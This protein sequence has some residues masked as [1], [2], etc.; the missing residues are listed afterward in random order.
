MVFDPTPVW[1]RP[2]LLPPAIGMV[3]D[4]AFDDKAIYSTRDSTNTKIN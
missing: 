2:R 4:H 3:L 1:N